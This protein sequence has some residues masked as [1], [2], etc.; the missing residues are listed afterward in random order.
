MK[1]PI[2]PIAFSYVSGIFCSLYFGLPTTVVL[3]VAVLSF[4]LL[5]LLYILQR[6]KGFNGKLNAFTFV[7]VFFTFAS[8]GFLIHHFTNKPVII[9]D[10][11]QKEFTIKV[12]EVLKSNHYSHRVYA[13]LL[14]HEKEP[15]VLVT[16]SNKAPLPKVGTVYTLVGIVKEVPE[17]RNLYDF[18]YKQYL[19]NKHIYYQINSNHAPFKIAEESSVH[20]LVVN[21]RD[22]LITQF[23]KLGYPEKTKGFIEALLFGIKTNLNDEIQ[24]QF[25][26]FG[27]LHVLAVSGMHVV[28]LFSTISYVLQHL[29]VPKKVV[30]VILI[31][32]LLIF[33]LMAGFSGS[34]VRAA[35]M[36]LM[37]IVGTLTGRRIYTINLLV[38]SML[39]ILLIEPNYL[40]DVGFQL[41][42]LAV[43]SI[44]FCYPVIQRF[45]TFKNIIL[46]YF[47]Q[48]VGV[49]L[50]AQLGVLPLNIYYF[51][52]IPLL[53]L[54]GNLIAIP[55]T[56]FLLCAWFLQMLLSLISVKIFTFFTS[57]L[58]S[59]ST[60]CFDSLSSLSDYFSVKTIDF[61]FNVFQTI[62][63]LLIVFC[64]F[65]FFHKKTVSK[66][67]VFL[68]LVVGF[69]F[70]S[71]NKL[72]QNG[73]EK[74]LVL[75]SDTKNMVIL[76]RVGCHIRQIGTASSYTAQSIK[77]YS[78]HNSA[79]ITKVDSLS[80]SFVLNNKTWLVVDSLSVY[81][82]QQFDYVVLYQNAKVNLERFT[83]YTQPKLI[84]LHNSNHQYL[85]DEYV[86][87]LM[88]RKIPYYDMRNK[89]S[90]VVELH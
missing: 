80:N 27:I 38:G 53:F 22:Y 17:P 78:M 3:S 88:E 60:F 19:K 62:L 16:F 12:T 83:Q 36:C 34:V 13:S 8:L 61:H 73:N 86:A 54:I 85:V 2:Y 84:V 72:Y 41:S 11:D 69:Q 31:V 9:T 32:F 71:V 30:T 25:K 20:K 48:L 58:N 66:V 45:F 75:L 7:S 90:Y 89:G 4:L 64:G 35:L 21:F 15:D 43:F 87:Y 55:L 81:P 56:S 67:F 82:K 77:N 70:A 74:E 49:S 29:R 52:Q 37:A 10:L 47:G 18:N 51:K 42:Y 40:F 5:V 1:Y 65:W 76:N 50:V 59:I 24:Q 26:D 46:N 23:D 28:L 63:A 14:S 39:L 6:N 33:S 57:I 44:V 68:G 79:V